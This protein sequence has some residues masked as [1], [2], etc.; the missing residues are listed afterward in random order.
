MLFLIRLTISGTILNLWK[1]KMLEKISVEEVEVVTPDLVDGL[2]P[3]ITQL[4]SKTSRGQFESWIQTVINFPTGHLFL[5]REMP[6]PIY[7]MLTMMSYPLLE[8]YFKAWIEDVVVDES[9]RGKGIGEL[10]V[11]TAIK[12]ARFEGL[13]E[14]NLTSNPSRIAANKLYQ[15]IGFEP[16]QTNYYRYT[17][18]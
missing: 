7:G 14:V 15:K 1:N 2:Y 12:Q 8:G 6:K 3:L 17:I 16:Y 5:A 11:K 18:T 13:K 9:A 10:L 4:S